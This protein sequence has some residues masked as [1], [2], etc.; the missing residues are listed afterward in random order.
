MGL[1]LLPAGGGRVLE[2][3]VGSGVLVPTLTARYREYTGTDLTLAPGLDGLVA[4]DCAAS[5]CAPICCR[6]ICRR[7][8]TTRSSASRCWSTSPTPRG[9]ARGLA[10]SL[11]PG[12]TLVCGYPMVS[13]LMSRAFTMIGYKNIDDDHVSPPVKIQAALSEVLTPVARAAFPPAAPVPA[14]LYQCTSWTKPA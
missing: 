10:R 1:D 6:T 12:G 13:G 14:A 2:V 5:S 8:I 9:A 7:I 11:A 3:G 4:P